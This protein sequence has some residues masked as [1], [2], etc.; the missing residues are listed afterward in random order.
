VLA[1]LNKNRLISHQSMNL[2]ERVGRIIELGQRVLRGTTLWPPVGCSHR[3]MCPPTR[4]N[5]NL[6]VRI[7]LT[8]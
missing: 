1:L 4:A 3:R 6:Y 5:P 7:C 8:A 2:L